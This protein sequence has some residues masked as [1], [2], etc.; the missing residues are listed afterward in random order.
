[1]SC[2]SGP[3]PI[4]WH[5]NQHWIGF[6]MAIRLATADRSSGGWSLRMSGRIPD[7]LRAPRQL[8][9]RIYLNLL[10]REWSKLDVQVRGWRQDSYP[11]KAW[12]AG[13]NPAALTMIL[14]GPARTHG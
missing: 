1:M 5:M 13:S 12:V 6:G 11:S 9:A 7:T 2:K 8:S 3:I 10:G 14:R 4:C